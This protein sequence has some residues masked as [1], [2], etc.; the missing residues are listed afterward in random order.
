[1]QKF[2]DRSIKLLG[3]KDFSQISILDADYQPNKFTQPHIDRYSRIS[4]VLRGGLKEVACRKE[5]FAGAG[6]IVFKPGDMV[7]QN[8][9]GPSGTRIV[10]VLFKNSVV[11]QGTAININQWQWL[12]GLPVASIAYQFARKL[13]GISEEEEVYEELINFFAQLSEGKTRLT[14]SPP[15]WLSSIA[16]KIQ[17]E[18]GQLIRTKD[19]AQEVGVHPVYLARIFRKYYGCSVKSYLQKLRIER[20]L[21]DLGE[22]KKSVVEIALDAGFSDQSHLTRLFKKDLDMSPGAFRKWLVNYQL[23]LS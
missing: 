13:P 4:I 10:S 20:A 3:L 1:M 14:A 8:S 23:T 19:L 12:H 2:Q 7:H 21:E 18:F 9:Y 17:D 15:L 22:R 5:A 6:S 11:H 16:E